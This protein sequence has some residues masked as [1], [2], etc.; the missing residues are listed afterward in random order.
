MRKLSVTLAFASLLVAG[1]AFAASDLNPPETRDGPPEARHNVQEK[2]KGAVIKPPAN[3]DPEMVTKPPPTAGTM[4]VIPPPTE[5]N[6]KKIVP[7]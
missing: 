5:K 1:S 2:G 6:G 3:V 4:P 7:K